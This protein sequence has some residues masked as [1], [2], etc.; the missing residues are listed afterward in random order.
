MPSYRFKE[1]KLNNFLFFSDT[2][3]PL[4]NQGP[5][6]VRGDFDSG[7]QGRNSNEAGKS[8]LF[9]SVPLLLQGQLPTGKMSAKD[10]SPIDISLALD[11]SKNA[12]EIGLKKNRYRILKNNKSITPHKKPDAL[13]LIKSLFPEETLFNS[14]SFVS[15]FSSIYSALIGGTPAIR[16]KVIEDFLDQSKIVRWKERLKEKNE[17]IKNV[18]GKRK[19]LSIEI[20]T[21]Q[22][23]VQKI[24]GIRKSFIGELIEQKQNTQNELVKTRKLLSQEKTRHNNAIKYKRIRSKL[25]LKDRTA[26]W[27][28]NR[29]AVLQKAIDRLERE[30]NVIESCESELK[31]YIELGKPSF[32][33]WKLTVPSIIKP[34]RIP[35]AMDESQ[36]KKFLEW[37]EMLE[38][39]RSLLVQSR[40]KLKALK[41]K[42]KCPTCE[43]PLG[44][45]RIS[46]VITSL[47]KR[48]KVFDSK[49]GKVR[50]KLSPAQ[51][52]WKIFNALGDLDEEILSAYEG[53]GLKEL[54]KKQDKAIEEITFLNEQLPLIISMKHF[55]SVELRDNRHKI[56]LLEKKL[57]T[58]DDD[59]EDIIRR[60]ERAKENYKQRQRL[61]KRIKVLKNKRA[62]L[63]KVTEK[64]TIFLPILI[65]AI[66]SRDL[67]TEVTMDFC[68][69]LT[70]EW[71][72]FASNLFTKKISFS[73]G[74]EQ[75]YPAFHFA[76]NG[77]APADIRH[78]SGGAKK[79]L[80]ACMIPS[81]LK[82]TPS[83]TNILVVDELDANLDASGR[84][85]IMDF[86]PG[87]LDSDLGK[88]SIFFLSART[89]IFH[90]NYAN[91]TVRR[92]GNE[93][94]LIIE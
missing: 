18:F 52:M 55:K 47:T 75:G 86:L 9:S 12:Y 23:E 81:F 77:S 82:I 5:V 42:K 94:K 31:K 39:D 83:P 7:R 87:I 70:S 35:I 88:T 61:L 20:K 54:K 13:R 27:V 43:Y 58:L 66:G 3:L 34:S 21:H 85:A 38:F 30:V 4:D 51:A 45:K 73:V 41:G 84:E 46:K 10:S 17:A 6:L 76:Y 15:Q 1:A 56:K 49:I 44:L 25:K 24:K 16:L 90:P 72:L 74:V 71:N 50:R 40:S 91:W 33:H 62:E 65:K 22:K 11:I 32:W 78:L 92:A 26:T 69:M 57:S 28:K 8:L 80:I 14:I 64:D 36:V 37:H 2:I 63:T 19:E 60:L 53:Y 48:I 68:E 29:I 67:K 89:K 79:R 59:L 93:S